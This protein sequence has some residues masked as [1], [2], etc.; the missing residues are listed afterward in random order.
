MARRGA[1]ATSPRV[2]VIDDDQDFRASVRSLL[3][4][5]GYVVFEAD[6]GTDGLRKVVEHRPNLIVLDVMM[7]C[8]SEGYGVNQAI[9]H[10]EE[11]RDYRSIPVVMTSSIELSPDELFPMAG[12]V[13]MIR[14]DYYLTKPLDIPGFLKV[15]E[16]A[17]SVCR[18]RN[19]GEA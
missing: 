14:P 5:H 13:E 2:L 6:S 12:E 9:K 4:N 3:E 15:V 1:M 19:A 16:R 7:K 11:Y 18:S 17:A 8:S 10:Q